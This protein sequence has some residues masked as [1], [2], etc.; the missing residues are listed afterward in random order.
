MS[1]LQV[2]LSMNIYS[3]TISEIHHFVTQPLIFNIE[4]SKISH[5]YTHNRFSQIWSQSNVQLPDMHC[6][7][8]ANYSLNQQYC[9]CTAV[10]LNFD[11][12][13]IPMHGRVTNDDLKGTALACRT[14]QIHCCNNGSFGGGGWFDPNGVQIEY[15][16]KS[17][18]QAFYSTGADQE[19]LLIRG[20]GT[21]VQGMYTCKL[22][23]N[24]STTKRV[25]VGL[26]N[27]NEG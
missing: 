9:H 24:S 4:G 12:E 2:L 25:Y 21:P 22:P 6:V 18:S 20:T 5:L 7:Y 10:Y 17:V 16:N 11:G 15:G 19:I 23:D 27:K 14:D 8:T 3:C 1:E 13:N 26:Y